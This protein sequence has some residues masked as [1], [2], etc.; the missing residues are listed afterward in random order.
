MRAVHLYIVPDLRDT[1]ENA[2][3]PGMIPAMLIC[4]V[5]KRVMRPMPWRKL[6]LS[7]AQSGP[8]Q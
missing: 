3:Q 1:E 5:C 7:T 8:R 4:E 6:A 2:N